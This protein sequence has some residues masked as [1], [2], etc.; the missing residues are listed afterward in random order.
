MRKFIVSTIVIPLIAFLGY[1]AA[2]NGVIT[3]G[4]VL[5]ARKSTK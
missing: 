1:K 2:V 4:D 3:A 5:D